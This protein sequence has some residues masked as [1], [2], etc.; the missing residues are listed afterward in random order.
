VPILDE[1]GLGKRIKAG[2]LAELHLLWGEDTRRL[3]AVVDAVEATIDPADRPFAVERI[4]AGEA[5]GSPLDIAASARVYPM[6]GDRRIVIVLRAER[7]LKPRRPAKAAESDEAAAVDPAEE[8]PAADVQPLLDYVAKPV[9]FTSLV[10]VATDIDRSRRLTKLVL[11]HAQV[12]EFGGL[13]GDG[14][15]AWREARARAMSEITEEMARAGRTLDAG[16]ARL[17]AERAGGDITRLRGDLERLLLYTE[18]DTRISMDDVA[19]VVSTDVAVEDEWAVVNA[20]GEGDAKRA[21]RE[22]GRR[23]DR[24]DSPHGVVGQLRWWVS[25]KL[26][27]GDPSR[28]LPALDALLRTDLAL[29]S[30]GGGEQMLV[31]RLV[32]ELTGRP[33]PRRGW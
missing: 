25:T 8:S 33:L 2:R 28:V 6:L 22:V 10:F 1:A 7:L 15:G 31:E 20:I 13:A 14:P 21:L 4:Y 26:A 9:P 23:F 19:D 17:L 11:Q 32:I 16:G 12:T 3:D 27:E 5:G 24:G 29:K 30:S 18:G